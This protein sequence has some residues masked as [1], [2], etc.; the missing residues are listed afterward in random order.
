[1]N[2]LKSERRWSKKNR[3]SR[4]FRENAR[5]NDFDHFYR[6]DNE[7]EDERRRPGIPLWAACALTGL[8][9]TVI[10]LFAGLCCLYKQHKKVLKLTTTQLTGVSIPDPVVADSGESD[11]FR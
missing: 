10:A 8:V 4:D 9:V 5:T 7:I 11:H 6:D 1:M 2:E 3:D